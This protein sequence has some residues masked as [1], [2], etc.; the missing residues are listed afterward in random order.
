[1]CTAFRRGH[2]T[3]QSHEEA[4]TRT[5]TQ[6]HN[7]PDHRKGKMVICNVTED[8]TIY[9]EGNRKMWNRRRQWENYKV[10]CLY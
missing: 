3:A 6:L 9:A 10:N 4:K 2:E 1:L 8:C 5:L 7:V